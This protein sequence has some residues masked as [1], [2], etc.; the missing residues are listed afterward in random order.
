MYRV[1]IES[2]MDFYLQHPNKFEKDLKRSVEYCLIK[3]DIKAVK[4]LEE[5]LVSLITLFF[6][7]LLKLL[8]GSACII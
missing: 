4:R 3:D 8:T 6:Y 5:E 7:I 1:E 2:E